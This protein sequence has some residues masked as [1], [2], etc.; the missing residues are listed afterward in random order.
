MVRRKVIYYG[1]SLMKNPVKRIIFLSILLALALSC[2]AGIVYLDKVYLPVK[3]K[4]G[5]IR[6]LEETLHYNVSIAKINFSLTNGIVIRDIRVYD[7]IQNKE[8]TLLHINRASFHFLYLPLLKNK[9]IIIP[10]LHIYSPQI[11]LRYRKDGTLNIY[12]LFLPGQTKAANQKNNLTPLIYKINVLQ[13]SLIFEDERQGAGFSKTIKNLDMGLA[14]RNLKKASFIIH[15]SLVST[16]EKPSR[17]LLKGDYNFS[18][19]ELSAQINLINL[20]LSEYGPYL[21]MLPFSV[22]SGRIENTN[23]TFKFSD[24]TLELGGI[25][26]LKGIEAKREEI[27]LFADID[28]LPRLGYATDTKKFSYSLRFRFNAATLKGIRYIESATGITGELELAKDMLKTGNLEFRALDSTF[29]LDGSLENFLN[30]YLTLMLESPD[31]RLEK[32][33]LF[34]NPAQE[35]NLSGITRAKIWVKGSLKEL[36]PDI[37]TEFMI[38]DAKLETPFSKEALEHIKGRIDLDLNSASWGDLS[39]NYLD[40]SYTTTGKLTDFKAPQLN[41]GINSKDLKLVSDI[42]INADLINIAALTA[43]YISSDLAVKGVIRMQEKDNPLLE[44]DASLSIDPADVLTFLPKQLAENIRKA[45]PEGKI[46]LSGSISGK[47][48]DYKDWNIQAQGNSKI[49][50]LYNLKFSNLF[51]NL[52]QKERLLNIWGLSAGAYSGT[53]NLDF[54]SNLNQ[55]NPTYAL[56]FSSLGIDLGQLRP[57]TK[58]KD[59]EIAG[60]LNISANLV[61]N[62]QDSASLKGNGLLSV[63]N[64]RLWKL[65][66]LKG[67]GELF[68]LPD[69]EKIIF[70][71]ARA[72]F[73]I[74]NRAVSTED[75][76]LTSDKL[77]LNCEGS[78]G[79]NGSLNF[80]AYAQVNKALI[81]ESSDLRKFTAA[82]LGELGNAISVKI[83][84]T[85]QKPRYH[86][87]P[88]PLDLIKKVKDFFSGK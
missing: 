73:N 13:G 66:L 88:I 71:E 41:F 7:K 38:E 6:S 4:S 60:I 78:L 5:L 56:K 23:L 40:T 82:I 17:I 37:K 77:K 67:L 57:D 27:S 36:P 44:L 1:L 52:L 63:Q 42:K 24:K 43:T 51:F 45:K 12:K 2:A 79:F 39:F 81:R 85:I 22:S 65:N 83:G 54:T 35:F 50:S 61:G 58:L 53:L 87:V 80:I 28:I 31:L 49:L 84:G 34:I 19:A 29:K 64:G 25:A 68:L 59:K 74:E 46:S 21:K 10:A 16:G 75:L 20:N 26:Y 76:Q 72:R 3:I 70:K 30:P 33:L 9:E 55:P 18:P 15:G 62:F 47:A 11:N 32:A 8:N 14:V 48:K 86:L 69:Y